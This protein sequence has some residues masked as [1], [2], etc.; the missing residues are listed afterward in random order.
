MTLRR[1]TVGMED[2]RAGMSRTRRAPG[3][4]DSPRLKVG[5]QIRPTGEIRQVCGVSRPQASL[6]TD[7]E[8]LYTQQGRITV[9]TAGRLL[10]VAL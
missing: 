5:S 2:D 3:T 7:A 9:S 1:P 4:P 8:V 6:I 10:T